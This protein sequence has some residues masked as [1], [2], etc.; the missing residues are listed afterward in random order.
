MTGYMDSQSIN[1]AEL[2]PPSLL[3]TGVNWS[4]CDLPPPKIVTVN[5]SYILACLQPV[6]LL[7]VSKSDQGSPSLTHMKTYITHP[8]Y[9]TSRNPVWVSDRL[10]CLTV[11][12]SQGVSLHGRGKCFPRYACDTLS[13][14]IFYVSQ[15]SAV[16]T[17]V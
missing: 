3:N 12:H 5:V 14:C 9:N 10:E 2:P 7:R 17:R 1:K 13:H 16:L 11:P 15:D 8:S 6:P 4:W